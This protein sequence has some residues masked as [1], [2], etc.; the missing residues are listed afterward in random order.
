MMVHEII[1][2]SDHLP[3]QRMNELFMTFQFVIF[4]M[5]STVHMTYIKHNNYHYH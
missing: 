5:K 3:Y 2:T 4:H 1:D